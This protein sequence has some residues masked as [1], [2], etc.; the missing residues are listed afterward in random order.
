MNKKIVVHTKLLGSK[1]WKVPFK[2]GKEGFPCYDF[3]GHKDAIMFFN[4]IGEN[5]EG[6]TKTEV[7]IYH[8]T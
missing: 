7:K 3:S 8:N 5:F 4:T 2:K 6:F 1:Y